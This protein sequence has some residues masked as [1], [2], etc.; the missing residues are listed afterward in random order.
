LVISQKENLHGQ[1]INNA[2][3]IKKLDKE[4]DKVEKAFRKDLELYRAEGI[5]TNQFK[6]LQKE[7]ALVRENLMRRRALL[8]QSHSLEESLEGRVNYVKEKLSRFFQIDK[9]D[10]AQLKM[11][12]SDVIEKV[13]VNSKTDVEIYYRGLTQELPTASPFLVHRKF[14]S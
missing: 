8:E 12:I 11:F 10:H 14:N 7:N 2:K 5:T 1:S 4:L 9:S 13:V 6:D 3:E